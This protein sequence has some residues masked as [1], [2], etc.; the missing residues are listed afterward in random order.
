MEKW[1]IQPLL[2]QKPPNRSLPKFA[3]V[4]MSG[5]SNDTKNFIT[6]GLL[7]FPKYAK[8]RIK[9]LG[10]FLVHPS[11]YSQDPCTDC[12]DQYVKWRRF[13]QRCAFSGLQDTILHFYSIFPAKRKFVGQFL[14]AKSLRAKRDRKSVISHQRGQFD[15]KFQVQGVASTN[16]FCTYS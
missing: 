16:H 3:W 13:A 9:W 6:I 14:T 5:T 8:M 15:P 4:I 11:A 7:P 2:P 12:H 10:Y 1:D